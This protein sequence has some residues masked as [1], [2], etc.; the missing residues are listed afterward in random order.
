MSSIRLIDEPSDEYAAY[1]V[2]DSLTDLV[3]KLVAAWSDQGM[4]AEAEAPLLL[5]ELRATVA[6]SDERV[7]NRTAR[8]LSQ[9]KRGRRR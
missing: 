6:K 1:I 7:R 3:E 9:M 8:M 5:E 4:D 2:E